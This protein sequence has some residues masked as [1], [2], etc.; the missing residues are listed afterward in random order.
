MTSKILIV[1]DEA[2]SL[3]LI[4]IMLQRQG[5]EIALA[6]N[7]SE[8]LK[9]AINEQPDL[10]ILDVMMP[11]MDGYEVC[12]RLRNNEQTVNIPIIMFTAKT[13]VDDKV[14]G[15]EAGADDYLTKPTHPA[16]LAARVQAVLARS[17][18]KQAS[19]NQETD[20]PARSSMSYAF[21][22]SKGGVGI[23]TLAANVAA[24]IAPHEST[25]IVDFRLGMGTLGIGLGHARNT[26]LATLLK[27]NSKNINARTVEAQ[28][29]IHSRLNLKML[30]SSAR[31]RETQ[32]QAKLTPESAKA[33]IKSLGELS[34][35]VVIDF[36]AGLNPLTMSLLR[37]MSQIVVAVEPNR[38][39]LTLARDILGELKQAGIA[40]DKTNVVIISR[41]QSNFQVAWQ[42][43]EVFLEHNIAAIISPVP[44]L[45]F[46]AM[47]A[48]LPLVVH[49]PDTIVAG[50]FTKL[51]EG[52]V[53]Q[54]SPE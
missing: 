43:A 22:G 41:A 40:K 51:A 33:I 45:A 14:A 27:D 53:R 19:K 13:L 37:D 8:A 34:D 39:S 26:G 48:E 7:G 12:R 32:L 9:G 36:G 42:D 49:Y 10:I 28:L 30:L 38:I 3:K 20:E 29:A 1:D 23:T 35:H 44:E 54:H 4:G 15:F 17:A 18:S 25:S 52:L 31:T 46:Q 50:Q 21:I 11:D 5:Y 2:D 47:E 16:E 24:S 6:S